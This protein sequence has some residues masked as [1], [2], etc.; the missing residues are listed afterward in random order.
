MKANK[1]MA[2][3]IMACAAMPAAAQSDSTGL[4][5]AAESFAATPIDVGADVTIPLEEST[6]AVSVITSAT[7]DRRSSRN[8]ANSILGQGTGLVSLQNSGSYSD[9]DPTFYVR[10]LQSLSTSTPLVLVDGIERSISDI[11]PGEVESVQILKDAAAV[12]L[13][14]YKAANGAILVTTKRGKYNTK[15]VK[16]SYDHEWQFMVKKPQFVDAATYAEAV[17]EAR[18]NDGLSA[19]YTT[20]EINAFRSGQYPYLYPNVDWV[21]ETFRNH[22]VAN[23]YNM[24]FSGGGKAFR[25]FTYI[26]LTT[27]KGFVANADANSGYSTQ[28]KYTK[29]SIRV[30]LDADITRTTKMKVNLQGVLDETSGPSADLWDLVYSVPA[31]AFPIKTESGLWGGTSTWSGTLNPVAQSAGAAYVKNHS[32]S[33][34]SDITLSQDL[35]GLLKGLKAS[36]RVGYDNSSN[37][38]EDHSKTYDY[39]SLTPGQWVDGEPT[40]SAEYKVTAASEMGTSA[41]TNAYAARFHFDA[42]LNYANTFG[43]HSVYSQFKWDYEYEDETGL[44]TTV[45][46]QNVSWYTHYGYKGRYFADLALVGSGSSRL[47]PGTKWSFSPTVSA[48]WVISKENFMAKAKWL[49]LLKLRASFGIINADY[50]PGDDVWTYYTQQYVTTG[51]TYPFTSSW[52]SEFGRTYLDRLATENPGHEKAYK[53]NVGLDASLFGCLNLTFDAYYQRRTDIWVEADGKYTALIGQDAPYENAGIVDSW[54]FEAGADFSRKV[55]AVTLT[56]GASV[57]LNRNKIVEQ[58]EEPRLY[59]N[60]VQTGHSVGQIY[61]LKAIGFFED[62]EDIANS[63]TQT[64]STVKPGDIK[65]ED[66]NGDGQIDSND[67][68]AIGYSDDAPELYFSLKLG[69]EWRG[70]GFYALL[71][72]TGRYSA[73]LNTKSMYWGLVD[74]TTIS[75]YAYENRWTADNKDAKYPRLSSQS[76]ANNYQTNT[77]WLED[78]SFLKLRTLEVYYNLPR[79]LLDAWRFISEAKLYLRGTDLF[80]IDHLA[81]SDPESYGATDPLTRSIAAGLAVTF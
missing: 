66:V 69:A 29:G 47:A 41:E 8:I 70:L 76:N 12:A 63:P 18:S 57:S 40:V 51:G 15:T 72:G 28:D 6:A 50:L 13:Y 31:A 43:N 32:R 45:Y 54:G 10:G 64:F 73:V 49:N 22:G 26:N 80:S 81:V 71:Q 39:G 74:N 4:K 2:A 62:E 61:G 25:Y 56:A 78:R 11:T 24:E 79:K 35:S 52:T 9:T 68:V 14:G 27:N 34:T 38:Y 75:Q 65:Y 17:N 30:N 5:S 67:E 48:A 23:K 20:D 42:G 37:V 21:N 33:L 59:D 60:L 46:R 53:Y 77:I 55:G 44:N 16:F 1:I 7:T 3:A 19:K 36:M 58:L